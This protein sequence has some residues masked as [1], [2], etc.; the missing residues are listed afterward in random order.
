MKKSTT[1]NTNSIFKN[2]SPVSEMDMM[3]EQNKLI[4]KFN[5]ND[6]SCL[7]KVKQVSKTR[8]NSIQSNLELDLN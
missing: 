3:N 1:Q 2:F 5:L 6:A 7:K 4:Q 8:K